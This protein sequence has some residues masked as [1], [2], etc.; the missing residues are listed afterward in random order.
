MARKSR[1]EESL[2][3]L[4]E[5]SRRPLTEDD[6]KYL[7]TSL[8]KGGHLIAGRAA[9]IVGERHLQELVP[10]LTRAFERFMQ[11]PAGTDKGCHA[12]MAIAEA[13]ETL[14]IGAI[15]V[16]RRGIRHV[17]R[18]PV[19]GGYHDTAATLRAMCAM[20]LARLEVDDI[21][22]EL[23][24]L[25][26]D[27]E[28]QA[29]IGA[30]RALAYMNE[31]KG[32]LLLRLKVVTGD[33]VAEVLSECF[34]ALMSLEPDRSLPFVAAY[35]KSP[36]SVVA[37]GAALALGESRSAAATE[38]LMRHRDAAVDRQTRAM[39]LLP[40]ALSRRQEALDYLMSVVRCE[41]AD[42]AVAA[43]RALKIY[44]GDAALRERIR[45]VV[46]ERGDIFMSKVYQEAFPVDRQ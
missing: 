37:E 31:E 15:E 19:F 3:R 44:A 8:E 34:A 33:G 38:A 26:G 43:V 17:Q 9:K 30:V 42:S 35:L 29:R 41:H 6:L 11:D 18:E 2:A 10:G 21:F 12:K 23:T 1:T 39:L 20:A 16:F 7:Q 32:E 13:L 28:P 25:L 4:T 40:I 45:L 14:E 27:P 24:A 46:M 36:D 5:L 22:F